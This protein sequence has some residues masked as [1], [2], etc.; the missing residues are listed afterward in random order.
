ML[1]TSQISSPELEPI[2]PKKVEPKKKPTGPKQ[3]KKVPGTKKPANKTT[4]KGAEVDL[5]ILKKA[6]DEEIAWLSDDI[7]FNNPGNLFDNAY[8]TFHESDKYGNGWN[9]SGFIINSDYLDQFEVVWKRNVGNSKTL[10]SHLGGAPVSFEIDGLTARSQHI[11]SFGR[12]KNISNPIKYIDEASID[13]V[14]LM[15]R[16]NSLSNVQWLLEEMK[17]QVRKEKIEGLFDRSKEFKVQLKEVSPISLKIDG[18][19]LRSMSDLARI[20]N[21]SNSVTLRKIIYSKT[22]QTWSFEGIFYEIKK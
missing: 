15:D 10:L 1:F 11:V 19:G 12:R 7:E 8:K 17:E 4:K 20:F 6:R 5:E 16:L 22:E 21:D 18:L 14:E 2:I 3:A 13:R 9:A